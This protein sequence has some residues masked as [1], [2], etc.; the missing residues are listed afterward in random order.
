M[1]RM[2]AFS[3]RLLL[4]LSYQ[5]HSFCIRGMAY[6]MESAGL[7]AQ[8][9]LMQCDSSPQR[10]RTM[11]NTIGNTATLYPPA[12]PPR[13]QAAPGWIAQA[14]PSRAVNKRLPHRNIQ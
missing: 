11:A 13:F 2:L 1:L 9:E 3:M 7:S 5:T 10:R 4:P 14:R 6:I 8:A 12:R